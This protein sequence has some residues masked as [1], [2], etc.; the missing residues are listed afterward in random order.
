M[1]EAPMPRS[2]L[3]IPIAQ[4]VFH[5]VIFRLVIRKLLRPVDARLGLRAGTGILIFDIPGRL[6]VVG[7]IPDFPALGKNVLA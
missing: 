7:L 3:R 5:G 1:G 2:L 4:D 6:V